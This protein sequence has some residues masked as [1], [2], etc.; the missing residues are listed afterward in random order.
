MDSRGYKRRPARVEIH[1]EAVL[2]EGDGCEVPVVI[3]D[4][5]RDGFRL[6]S[7]DELELGEEVSLQVAKAAPVRARIQW[8]R[9]L[10]AGGT[11]LDAVAL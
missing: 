10:E 6:H 7:R 4:V 8:T 2:I 1:R 5:S 3:I 11:F 9:G